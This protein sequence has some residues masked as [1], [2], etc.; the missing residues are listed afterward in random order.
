MIQRNSR[1][2]DTFRD[3][4]R[5]KFNKFVIAPIIAL[6]GISFAFMLLRTLRFFPL[7]PFQAE[8]LEWTRAWLWT[9]CGDFWTLAACFSFVILE[10]EPNRV[11]AWAW[12]LLVNLLGSPFACL[13]LVK[14][15]LYA[16]G[17]GNSGN[18]RYIRLPM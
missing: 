6:L 4:E 14:R 5:Y 17:R 10:N 15:I 8:S 16:S 7:F 18:E 9:T 3:L 12:V 1:L 13:Y 2:M 11:E